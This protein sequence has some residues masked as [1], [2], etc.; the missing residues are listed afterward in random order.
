MIDQSGEKQM[1][2]EIKVKEV[3]HAIGGIQLLLQ[4]L[5][6]GF[7]YLHLNN[8][9][10]FI[11]QANA[12]SMRACKKQFSSSIAQYFSWN[13]FHFEWVSAPIMQSCVRSSNFPQEVAESSFSYSWLCHPGFQAAAGDSSCHLKL[14]PTVGS[15]SRIKYV[16]LP[17]KVWWLSSLLKAPGTRLAETLPQRSLMSKSGPDLLKPTLKKPLLTPLS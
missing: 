2:Q 1:N 9:Q 14:M 8:Y 17:V 13:E 15:R 16:C 12:V 10:E 11:Q 7:W 6:R 3:K 5:I 4:D